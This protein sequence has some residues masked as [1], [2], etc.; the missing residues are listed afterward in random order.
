MH[1]EITNYCTKYI[2][3]ELNNTVSFVMEITALEYWFTTEAMKLNVNY[4][5]ALILMYFVV[6]QFIEEIRAG[7]GQLSVGRSVSGK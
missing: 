3:N 5:P 6:R 7:G 1:D 2:L 4:Y